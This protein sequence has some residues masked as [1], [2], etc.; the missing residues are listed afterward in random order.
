MQPGTGGEVSPRKSV[1]QSA[2]QYDVKSL[3]SDFQ[4]YEQSV[5]RGDG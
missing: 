4:N 1:V 2:Y 3:V 5:H